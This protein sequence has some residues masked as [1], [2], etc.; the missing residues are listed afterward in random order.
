MI[1]SNT[2]GISTFLRLREKR[3]EIRLQLGACL[4]QQPNDP[5]LLKPLVLLVKAIGTHL[6]TWILQEKAKGEKPWFGSHKRRSA[7]IQR[8]IFRRKSRDIVNRNSPRCLRWRAVRHRP[9]PTHPP[10]I[11]SSLLYRKKSRKSLV[12]GVGGGGIF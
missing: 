4:P 8:E 9:V 3:E 12:W 6:N 2:A 5:R 1:P 10:P 11:P 7:F